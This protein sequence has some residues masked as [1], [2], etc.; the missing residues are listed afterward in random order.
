MQSFEAFGYRARVARTGA[1]FVDADAPHRV[2]SVP[3]RP[4]S[5][6][7]GGR[8]EEIALAL[9]WLELERVATRD[10][11]PQEK[12]VPP[13]GLLEANDDPVSAEGSQDLG[14]HRT[15]SLPKTYLAPR[16]HRHP[17]DEVVLQPEPLSSSPR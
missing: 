8:L 17:G 4:P 9:R 3:A 1:P 11:N 13:F 12:C 16:P 7:T 14:K 5:P 6:E 2:S 15:K 10:R